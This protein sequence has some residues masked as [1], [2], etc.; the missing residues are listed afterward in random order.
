[1]DVPM[2]SMDAAATLLGVSRRTL[3]RRMSEFAR[4]SDDSR[5]R[6]ML[7]LDQILAQPTSMPVTAADRPTIL[8][9]DAGDAD[10]QN[11]LAMLLLGA[12]RMSAAVYWLELAAA[13]GNADAMQHLARHHLPDNVP[14][15]IM[16][17][18]K[19]ATLGHVIASAQLGA[20]LKTKR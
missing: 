17:L 4:G 11:D 2:I 16:W 15:G 6:A 9:A 8:R 14:V 1:M 7:S 20:A 18:A 10:A 13:Q 5:G 19:A 3:W 12:E